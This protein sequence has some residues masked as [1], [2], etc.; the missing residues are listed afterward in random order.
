MSY[1][2]DD[3][4]LTRPEDGRV[5]SLYNT[6]KLKGPEDLERVPELT[7]RSFNEDS[8]ESGGV[9]KGT[10]DLSELWPERM[11]AG[12]RLRAILLPTLT[13]NV[14]SS[15]VPCSP[16]DALLALAPSTVAQLPFSGEEDCRRLA[17]L[18]DKVPAY[19]LF[20]GS[21]LSQIPVLISELI[22]EQ[23]G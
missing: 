23:V 2:A 18:A 10:F 22:G 19:R 15:L 17:A 14:A 9:G 4:C 11:A 13:G 1:A 21:D 16:G 5:F 12:F 7:G 20:L 8:F 6:A 3:Y